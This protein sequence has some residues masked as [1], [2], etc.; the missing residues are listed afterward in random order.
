MKK[1]NIILYVWCSIFAIGQEKISLEESI[2]IG[3]KQNFDILITKSEYDISTIN[4]KWGNAGALPQINL[5]SRIEKNVSDQT[6][7]PTSFIQELLKSDVINAGANINWTLFNGFAIRANKERLEQLQNL[8]E[9]NFTLI[10]EN[11]VQSIILAYYNCVIQKEREKL[12][13]EIVN[14]SK[15]RIIYEQTRNE[16]GIS[17]KMEFLQMKNALLTDSSNLLIQKT[18]YINAV[19]NF[20][21]LLSVDIE[22]EWIFTSDI[23]HDFKLYKFED[24]LK[25]SLSDNTNI[26][27]QYI[28]IKLSEQDI[29][30]TK[31]SKYPMI[32]FNS[33]LSYNQNNYDIG[34]AN[35][36]Y[37]GSTTGRSL[38]YF[39]NLS[40]SLR[41]FNG[42]QV[43]NRIREMKIR[44]ETNEIRLKK[45][46]QEISYE[47]SKTLQEYNNNIVLYNIN[48]EAFDISK[49]NYELASDKKN[50]GIINSFT[51]RDIEIIYISSG[52]NY[53]QSSY[54]LLER[55]MNLLRISGGILQER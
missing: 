2:A 34:D 36:E 13:Q 14:L 54:N 41:I 43:Y 45:A 17:S 29:I 39:T 19:K 3:L 31:S 44:N 12:L 6:N 32:S 20:N 48:K 47:L 4:N 21:M 11:N 7:N 51:L 16:I 22:K 8:S 49:R 25:K 30:L 28:N 10:I 33:G 5:S 18:N 55:N 53:L 26:Q 9:N 50:R 15:E 35:I 38:N 42:G 46:K 37:T 23:K 40:M 1:Y 27:N 52:I 24:L